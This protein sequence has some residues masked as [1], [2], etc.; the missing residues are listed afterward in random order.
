MKRKILIGL[1]VFLLVAVAAVGFTVWR[2]LGEV[3]KMTPAATGEVVPGVLAIRDDFVNLYLV[4][5]AG[6]YVLFDG[7]N[8]PAA[9][10]EGLR[11]LG[12]PREEI[13]A[14]FLTHSDS[15]HRA[16]LEVLG[17][18]PLYVGAGEEAIIKG[19]GHRMFFM[20]NSLPERRRPLRG[21]ETVDAGGVI[22]QALRTPGHTP[23]SMCYLV[24]GR[25]LFT[26]DTI[27]LRD[28][29][30]GPFVELFNMDTPTEMESIR[31][32]A[33][34]ERVEAVFTGHHGYTKDFPGAFEAW[35]K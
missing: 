35:R 3:R 12:I 32:L 22:V 29:K 24:N 11:K 15:D 6:G 26:G 34:L 23:G 30:A 25:W 31:K 9:V 21:G 8:A 7:G 19:P 20:R 10:E 28:G 4:K 16:A 14:V 33:K 5:G 2:Y 1:G 13:R 18:V 17:D 27:S